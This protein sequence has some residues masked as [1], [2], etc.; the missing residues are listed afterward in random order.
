M[1]ETPTREVS[2][3]EPTMTPPKTTAAPM[4][5]TS[6]PSTTAY[7]SPPPSPDNHPELKPI[8][9]VEFNPFSAAVWMK[10]YGPWAV[11]VVLFLAIYL[12]Y[13]SMDKRLEKMAGLYERN[14]KQFI[15]LID[16]ISRHQSSRKN[17][18]SEDE[19]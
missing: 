9:S 19:K 11:C 18:K 7:I 1:N 2:S 5:T 4:Q 6:S 16:R 13:R 14:Q 10:E 8:V 15:S 12:L 3:L 17:D